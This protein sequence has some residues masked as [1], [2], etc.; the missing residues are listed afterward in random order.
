MEWRNTTIDQRT[1]PVLV[2]IE[3]EHDDDS[4]GLFSRRGDVALRDVPLGP[5]RKNLAEVVDALQEVFSEVAARD[6]VL[7]LKEAQ[8]SF[9]VTAGGGVQ[10]IGTT[11]IQGT[12]AVTLVF[13]S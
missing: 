6:G 10:L 9:Q 11:Q 13:K 3:E 1:L 5:L 12:R 4:M 2:S 7:S 8:L